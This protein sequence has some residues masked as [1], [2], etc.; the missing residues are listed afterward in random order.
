MN[1]GVSDPD[2]HMTSQEHCSEDQGV[3]QHSGIAFFLRAWH[4]PFS[5]LSV[6]VHSPPLFLHA[7]FPRRGL[8]QVTR[9]VTWRGSQSARGGDRST[10]RCNN[11]QCDRPGRG[12][13]DA[14]R[15]LCLGEWMRLS[16]G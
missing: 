2:C 12:W 10:T 11:P 9:F 6:W 3:S 14:M 1:P 7:T 4:D 8:M 13:V 16:M 5:F 15:S